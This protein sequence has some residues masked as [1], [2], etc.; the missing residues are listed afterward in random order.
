MVDIRSCD[1]WWQRNGEARYAVAAWRQQGDL[2]GSPDRFFNPSL[3][4]EEHGVADAEG[5]IL[6]GRVKRR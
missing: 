6:G 1:S 5:W 2:T 3:A 4:R